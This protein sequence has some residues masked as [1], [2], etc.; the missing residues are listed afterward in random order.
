MAQ[1][2][3]R[4]IRSA[5]MRA[6][7]QLVERI[8]FSR[9]PVLIVGETGV[10]KEV[11]AE[12]IHEASPR[13]AREMLSLNCAALPKDLIEGEL[14]GCAK[15][16]YTGATA[17]RDGLFDA[18][19]GSTIFLD[20]L[21]EM[22]LDL[23]TRFLRVLQDGRIRPVGRSAYHDVDVRVIS[24]L[25]RRPEALISE[26]LL[27]EDLYFRLS[28]VTITV[29]PLRER[30]ADIVPLAEAYLEY[31]CLA[32]E[33]P[34]MTLTDDAKQLLTDASWPGN[35]RQLINEMNRVAVL[36]YADAVEIGHLS[37]A[38]CVA[39]VIHVDDLTLME[40]QERVTIINV[41]REKAGNK[42]AAAK[43]LGI[44]RQTLYNKLTGYRIQEVEYDPQAKR[45]LASDSAA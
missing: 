21:S 13:S 19:H 42:L 20:E 40:K 15:G 1:K 10:G 6:L 39:D 27:R 7:Q 33:R 18:A 24:A 17:D 3:P 45:E 14:F 12:M 8:A 4:I 22:P 43:T 16:A 31:F 30:R 44:G 41:L 23:Q 29:P 36:R 38:L 28:T 11:V 5:E 2:F 34:P 35:V 9:A 37:P 26:H 25:N 32:L